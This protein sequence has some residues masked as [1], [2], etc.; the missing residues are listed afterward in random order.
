MSLPDDKS[1]RLMMDTGFYQFAD[2]TLP[3]GLIRPALQ[4][5]TAFGTPVFLTFTQDT[6]NQI[7]LFPTIVK[8]GETYKD[9]RFLELL[10]KSSRVQGFIGL[11]FMAR[12]VVT[13]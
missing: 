4:N 1:L 13:F 11:R 6:A 9:L 2:G 3:P 10:V 12:H 7:F 8:G 5:R